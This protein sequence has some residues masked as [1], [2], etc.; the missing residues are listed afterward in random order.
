MH[1][2]LRNVLAAAAL[3]VP[4]GC[5]TPTA[6]ARPETAMSHPPI[7]LQDPQA[8]YRIDSFEIPEAARPEL[9]AAM[10]RNL[11]FLRTL[12]GFRGHVAFEKSGGPSTFNL[13]TV[14]AWENREALDAAGKEVRAYYQRIGFDMAGTLQRWGVTMV[15]AE[16]QA[17]ARLQ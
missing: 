7:D 4:I 11:E 14:A 5:S 8:Y 17:P 9:E 13:V 1:S 15:R 3:M 6:G 10:R 2:A 12:P 16:Y